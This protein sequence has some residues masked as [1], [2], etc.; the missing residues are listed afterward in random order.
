[1]TTTA[2]RVEITSQP[3]N[4]A[5]GGI[6]FIHRALMNTMELRPTFVGLGEQT[7]Q[8]SYLLTAY[9]DLQSRGLKIGRSGRSVKLLARLVKFP[10]ESAILLTQRRTIQPST[11][12]I[13]IAPQLVILPA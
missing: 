10:P 8:F 4:S 3:L 2:E 7:F 11:R 6:Q 9:V 12:V 5:I 1:M 13:Q